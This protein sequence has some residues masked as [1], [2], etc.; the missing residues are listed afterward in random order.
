MYS[1][2]N[3]YFVK[4]DNNTPQKWIDSL[5]TTK[6]PIYT[7]D[8]YT[9]NND[10]YM[11]GLGRNLQY[12]KMKAKP[13]TP[14]LYMWCLN[15][16][17]MK[18][19]ISNLTTPNTLFKVNSTAQGYY[20]NGV[21]VFDSMV[22]TERYGPNWKLYKVETKTFQESRT[23]YNY[24]ANSQSMSHHIAVLGQWT[25]ATFLMMEMHVRQKDFLYCVWLDENLNCVPQAEVDIMK[26]LPTVV[27]DIE[28]VSDAD[29]RLPMGNY[30]ADYIMSV[31]VIIDDDLHTLFNLPV[32]SDA[33]LKKASQ[34]IKDVDSSNYYKVKNRYNEVFNKEIDLLKRFFE[35]LDGISTPYICLGYNS[36]G[37]DMPF[38]L[39]RT[40]YLNMPQ[41]SKF[42]YING[43][44]SYGKNMIHVD[45]NQVL[46]KFFAQELSSFSLKSVAKNLL[47]NDRNTQKVDFNARNLRYIYKYMAE[48][49]NI[50]D[51]TFD[52]AL[53]G[54][55]HVDWKVDI[56]TLAN[57][58]E[59]DCLV[60]LALWETLQYR[61]FLE[62]ASKHFFLPYT[63]LSLSKLNEYLSGNMIKMGLNYHTIFAKHH[64]TQTIKT[65]NFILNM[66]VD[67]V[68]SSSQDTSYGG[69]FNFRL[70]K[71]SYST[72]YAM[73]A[74][75][76][77]PE[78]IS[79]VNL[80]HET[81]SLI[82]VVDFLIIYH[83]NVE[84]ID[85]KN[86]T[87]MKFCTHKTLLKKK[88]SDKYINSIDQAITPF[89]Y[90]NYFVKNCEILTIDQ[91]KA[92][93]PDEKILVINNNKKGI[94]SKII[95][96]RN[97]LRNVAKSN[98][99]QVANHIENIQD[100]LVKY[101]LGIVEEEVD[102]FADSDDDDDDDNDTDNGSGDALFEFDINNYVI[103]NTNNIAEE[104][105]FVTIQLEFIGNE[106]FCKC[107]NPLL[108][109]NTY[110][111]HLNA[112]HLRLNS[113][114]RNMKLL[115]NS[116]YGLL[117]SSYGTLKAKNI[118]ATVTMLG[119]KYI[120]EAAKIGNRVGGSTIY[121]DTDSV[122][123]DLTHATVNKPHLH[124]TKEVVELNESVMLNVKIYKNVFIMGRKTYMATF[125]DVIFSRGI[126]K[127]GP[128]LW[129]IMKE[130]FYK[131]YVCEKQDLVD[132]EV[133]GLLYNMYQES[134]I[135][136]QKN[137]QQVLRTMSVQPRSAYKKETPITKLMDR[138]K[139][140]YPTYVFDKK[141]TCFHKTI[142]NVS[143]VHFAMDFELAKTDVK[144]INLYKFYNSI[145][146]ALYAIVSLAIEQ[147]F[148]RRYSIV[149]KYPISSF[150]RVNKFAYL[151][152]VDKI[153][154]DNKKQINAN[155][156][157]HQLESH[158]SN[159]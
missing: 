33:E 121:S 105:Y 84:N 28:T 107:K 136:I 125:N 8:W 75:A 98:K 81:T 37:Y 62:Y 9:F 79:G 103:G 90:I 129:N 99:K 111:Q 29:Y 91:I 159:S 120:I 110:L 43:I 109:I 119:R 128:I 66:D 147:T 42:Y 88:S 46:V 74:Q 20:N 38:L 100:L 152:H 56:G 53:C 49:D 68:A 31:T 117:G 112:E 26:E 6:G 18:G 57:Y 30:I 41:M 22:D 11:V 123:F 116:I 143:D 65:S 137:K 76:Y 55:H 151:T 16:R 51:G 124:I 3:N 158:H 157:Q 13:I 50:N 131:K 12:Q 7:L 97:N 48:Y 45:M 24:I 85:I 86:Y 115:N 32:T 153:K 154:A 132:D 130:K 44:L 64:S 89:G 108:A 10:F 134:Y 47:H 148:K 96:L 145:I 52:S 141:V 27:V 127:N 80:S 150:R 59:M 4:Y 113:H 87:F 142:G 118:A 35:L 23:L 15:E 93:H 138:I 25:L 83:N 77:Y 58:N 72:V 101:N 73:D 34:L 39:N 135:E 102:D 2:S 146:T 122:F 21:S 17:I 36:R 71:N 60:V 133:A 78:L 95:G 139:K 126:S 67:A 94:L 70:S 144:D 82:S 114:Y 155:E 69:G 5:P 104:E 54:Q 140:E 14:G 19:M 40:V 61:P 156:L 1:S 149:T 63:R 92:C 106:V